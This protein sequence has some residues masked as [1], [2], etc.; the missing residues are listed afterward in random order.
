[1]TDHLRK[2]LFNNF[3]AFIIF[4]LVGTILFSTVLSAYFHFI[5]PVILV[6]SCGIN[7]LVYY[8][9]TKKEIPAN[10]TTILISQS[11]AIKF[12]YYLSAASFF[13]FLVESQALKITFVLVLFVL[14]LVFTI[15][16][17]TALLRFFKTKTN[18][19]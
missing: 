13:V 16:E 7:L 8:L 6:L 18:N 9:F 2:F 19:S 15:L 4:G 17:V 1:M 10:R 14:Y 5:Y 11:F 3:I 12:V